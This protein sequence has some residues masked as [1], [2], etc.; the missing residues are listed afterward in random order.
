MGKTMKHQTAVGIVGAI[1]VMVII[2]MAVSYAVMGTTVFSASDY[3]SITALNSANAAVTISNIYKKSGYLY[4]TPAAT[5]SQITIQY[6]F[7]YG[8]WKDNGLRQ[9]T[10]DTAKLEV[11]TFDKL[12][13]YLT[14][15]TNNLYLGSQAETGASS[16]SITYDDIKESL[17]V[18]AKTQLKIVAVDVNGA[19]V[20]A[21]NAIE[22]AISTDFTMGGGY[23]SATGL[24]A[25]GLIGLVVA[26][27]RAIAGITS[28][29]GAAV[30]AIT[31]SEVILTIIVAI[32]ILVAFAYFVPRR[33]R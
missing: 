30:A 10:V 33:R 22:Q 28:A 13:F 27:K 20:D 8:D 19:A 25:A 5:A 24:I 16:F 1:A 6:S 32:A 26:F 14:D 9:I 31:T 15:G 18:A 17:T 11:T 3:T 29:L 7:T 23:Q 4:F 21:F 12:K 2:G